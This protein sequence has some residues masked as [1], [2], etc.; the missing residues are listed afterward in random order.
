[1]TKSQKQQER[2]FCAGTNSLNDG[3]ATHITEGFLT[4]SRTYGICAKNRKDE[5]DRKTKIISEIC[6]RNSIP[7]NSKFKGKA[8]FWANNEAAKQQLSPNVTRA[9]GRVFFPLLQEAGHCEQAL[10][11]TKKGRQDETRARADVA[12][13]HIDPNKRLGARAR[14]STNRLAG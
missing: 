2:Q 9:F 12:K 6:K 10:A 14:Q 4:N 7:K 11:P 13:S 5:T 3:Q 1:L 8:V